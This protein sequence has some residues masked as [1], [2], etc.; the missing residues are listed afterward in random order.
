MAP[1]DLN[2]LLMIV[3]FGASY[4]FYN[5]FKK[6]YFGKDMFKKIG[7]IAK[8]ES[9]MRAYSSNV[10]LR[11]EDLLTYLCE[12]QRKLSI[13]ENLQLDYSNE[14]EKENAEKILE[15]HRLYVINSY[16]SDDLPKTKNIY[17]LKSLEYYMFSLDCFLHPE[18]TEH[19]DSKGKIYSFKSDDR[20][21]SHYTLT[22]YGR[23]YYKLYLITLMFIGKNENTKKLFE[24][25]DP[26]HKKHIMEALEKNEVSFVCFW[27]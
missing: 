19:R 16:F 18:I 13:P 10:C 14:T 7:W 11:S 25:I 17:R 21:Y 1:E 3:L 24:Y 2:V 12:E 27:R 22:D 9:N 20:P 15:E 5:H 26:K 6:F 8:R 23:A 4:F